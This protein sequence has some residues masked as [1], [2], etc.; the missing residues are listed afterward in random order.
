MIY[1]GDKKIGEFALGGTPIAE[2]YMGADLVY[3]KEA[4]SPPQITPYYTDNSIYN[5]NNV[6]YKDRA[7]VQGDIKGMC[8]ACRNIVDAKLSSCSFNPN[9]IIPDIIA[10]YGRT[11]LFGG[12][13]SFTFDLSGNNGATAEHLSYRNFSELNPIACNSFGFLINTDYT[14]YNVDEIIDALYDE[15]V[16]AFTYFD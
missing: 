15:S 1:L 4:V 14:K 2:I 6:Y 5:N 16:L 7:S 8:L 9:E 13:D 10:Y 11:D 12:A 3:A